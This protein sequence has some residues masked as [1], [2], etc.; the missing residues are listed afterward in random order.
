MSSLLIKN[1]SQLATLA[2]SKK[3]KTC[4]SMRDA[5]YINDACVFI[6]DGVIAF[7][8]EK[9]KAPKKADR[10]SA[11]P[12]ADEIIDADGCC[13]SPGLIDAHT[14][15]VFSKTR[16]DEFVMRIMGK[17]YMEITSEGGGIMSSV[18]HLRETSKRDLKEITRKH[19]DDFLSNGTTTIEA[20]SGYGLNLDDEIKSLEIL[21]EL[22]EEHPIEIIPA[23]LGA[24]TI[25]AEYKNNREEFIR[26]VIDEMLPEVANRH[27]AKYCD[28]F[29]EKGVFTV[30][31]SRRILMR[32][33]ELGM[34]IRIHSDEFEAIGG[35]ELAG[36]LKAVSADHLTAI[37]YSGIKALKENGV[38]PILLPAT[39]FFLGHGHYAPARKMID[40]GL[41]IAIATDFN[42]GSS[43]TNSLQ[44]AMTIAC[45]NM[46]LL[47][48]EAL[49]ACTVNAAWSLGIL[50][51]VGSIEEGKQADLVIW[52]TKNF[53]QVVY[54]FGKNHAKYIIKA[55]NLMS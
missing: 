20:K 46:K 30:E 10:M 1:I 18:K 28:I 51:K 7:A 19:L 22:N 3:P 53:R 26:T 16:E 12:E 44:M 38:I 13:V 43:M 8:G 11:L 36:E 49:C 5:G 31:E 6:K 14:H 39:S 35:T 34:G 54:H 2:S 50:D 40:A 15:P 4:D 27:L 32:A 29:C 21:K 33:K 25:P 47:P 9:S 23:F 48:E 52:D 41:P 24:H 37:T 55:G 42:P 45:I 17:T